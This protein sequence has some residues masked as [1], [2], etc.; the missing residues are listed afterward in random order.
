LPPTLQTTYVRRDVPL[1]SRIPST[2]ESEMTRRLQATLLS[3]ALTLLSVI[4]AYAQNEGYPEGTLTPTIDL[5]LQAVALDVPGKY[6]DLVPENLT[7]DLPP[8]FSASVFAAGLNKPRLMAVSPEGVLHVCNMG[9]L[10]ILALPD[11]D[12][13]GVADEHI[14]VLDNLREA[15]SLSF[16]KGEMYVAEEHQIIRGIDADGDGIYED[17]EVFLDDIPWEGQHD[18]RT[19]VFDELNGTGYLSIGSPCDLC[20][21]DIGKQ[22]GGGSGDPVPQ[23]PDRGT[24]LQFNDDGSGRRVF[25]T[26]VRNVLGMALHP[27]TN[28][29]WGNN[30]G[31]DWEGRTSPP[32]WI[33][34]MRDGDFMGHPLVQGFQRWNDFENPRNQRVLPLTRQD[35]LLVQTQKRPVALVPAHWAPMG[36]HFYTGEQFPSRYANVAFVAFRAGKAKLSSHPG[37]KVQAL[38]SEPDGSNA[39]MADFLS[40]FQQGTEQSSVWGF[41]VGLMTDADGSLYVTSDARTQAILRITHSQLGGFLEPDLPGS[42]GLGRPLDVRLTAHLEPLA[43]ASGEPR[44]SADLSALGGPAELALT[45][46]DSVTYTLDARVI[47]GVVGPQDVI[48]RVEQAFGDRT[49]VLRFTQTIDVVAPTWRH[50]LPS[51]LVRGGHI[52][53]RATIHVETPSPEG[54]RPRVTVDLSALGGPER[55]ALE[56]LGVDDYR[57]GVRFDVEAPVGQHEIHIHIEQQ[58]GDAVYAHDFVHTVVI[59]PPDLPILDDVLAS[60]WQLGGVDGALV[61]GPTAD[62]PVFSGQQAQAVQA[63]PQSLFANWTLDLLPRE[64]VQ[65][66]GFVGLR[67]AFH[68][69]ETETPRNPVLFL[70]IDNLTLDLVRDPQ[71]GLAIDLNRREWQVLEIPFSAFDQTHANNQ[72]QVDAVDGIRIVGNLTGTFFLDDV[73]LVASIPAAPPTPTVVAE[74]HDDP[75]PTD[76]ALEQNYPNPF[77]SST[78]IL[79]ALADPAN[80]ALLVYN[81]AGQVVARLVEGPR[82]SGRHTVSWDGRADYGQEL[83]SGVYLLRLAAD[84]WTGTSIETRKLLLLR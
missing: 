10:E 53:L 67:F 24:V 20:R 55:V 1:F 15:H 17:R 82:P 3:G 59:S 14:V 48:V 46:I 35:T 78:V 8:G 43:E 60:D 25:A 30:N 56:A 52:D 9:A 80:V 22:V 37:Y 26:G 34:I 84:T 18:T 44:V 83:A 70:L 12:G 63:K 51:H 47:A 32:E 41:P 42:V 49:E 7:V 61:L 28:E 27:V 5:D 4:A 21:M 71:P 36:M 69:G 81:T 58:A 74:R 54:D 77:N 2:R 76:F 66:E 73:R 11:R 23:H 72:D 75:R 33:D 79:Y 64:P 19:L 40:G 68:P 13:D 62:G 38:F 39:V 57:L 29:L 16:Y 31:H 65:P 45:A 6:R 50:D